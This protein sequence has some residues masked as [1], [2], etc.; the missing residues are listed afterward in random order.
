M[1]HRNTRS[2]TSKWLEEYRHLL[3]RNQ[4]ILQCPHLW[5]GV[6]IRLADAALT[7]WRTPLPATVTATPLNDRTREGSMKVTE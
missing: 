5:N 6:T 7:H 2:T 1:T 4:T 3:T